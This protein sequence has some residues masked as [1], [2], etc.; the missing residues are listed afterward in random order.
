MKERYFDNLKFK[1]IR[2]FEIG[3]TLFCTVLALSILF[4]DWNVINNKADFNQ[5]LAVLLGG[6]V[7]GI[8][9]QTILNSLY[10]KK[11]KENKI[12]V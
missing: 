1:R 10:I 11:I 4:S 6:I 9:I 5:V 7:I 3:I 2:W 12:N 8:G